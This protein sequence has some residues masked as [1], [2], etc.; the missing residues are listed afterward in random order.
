[1]VIIFA[2]FR[3]FNLR[4]KKEKRKEKMGGV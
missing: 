3:S 4:T 2:N 1:L